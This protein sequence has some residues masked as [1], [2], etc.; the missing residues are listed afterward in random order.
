MCFILFIQCWDDSWSLAQLWGSHRLAPIA[1]GLGVICRWYALVWHTGWYLFWWVV[2]ILLTFIQIPSLIHSPSTSYPVYKKKTQ[3]R[4]IKW[5]GF[6]SKTTNWNCTR[7]SFWNGSCSSISV[8]LQ[9]S[10]LSLF[11]LPHWLLHVLLCTFS[12]PQSFCFLI[13]S[14]C[15]HTQ[16]FCITI[17][18]FSH[19]QPPNQLAHSV[20]NIHKYFLVKI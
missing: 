6:C 4:F 7:K 14:A 11:S 12:L 3:P 19:L 20:I 13:T 17:W 5:R 9:L 10:C 18:Y 15:Q 8:D 16:W 1:M 2:W